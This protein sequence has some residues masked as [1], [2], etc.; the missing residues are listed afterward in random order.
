[1]KQLM[2]KTRKAIYLLFILVGFSTVPTKAQHASYQIF[3]DAL[4]PYGQWIMDPQ[5]G[6]V[7]IPDAGPDFRPYY[8]NGRWVMTEYGN[9]WVSGY[10]WGWAPFHYGRWT[11]NRRFGWVWIP[12]NVWGPAWVSWRSGG[13]YYGW[14]PL[15]PGINVHIAFGNNYYVPDAWWTF[16]PCRYIYHKNFHHHWKGHKHNTTFIHNTTII[17]NTYNN[18]YV[19]GPR[20]A[21]VEKHVGKRVP[22]YELKNETQPGKSLVRNRNLNVYRP[23]IEAPDKSETRPAPKQFVRAEKPVVVKPEARVSAQPRMRKENNQKLLPKNEQTIPRVMGA[24]PVEREKVKPAQQSVTPKH[25]PTAQ[26]IQPNRIKPTTRGT[27]RTQPNRIE[28]KAS[29]AK[30]IDAQRQ[31]SARQWQRPVP[32]QPQRVEKAQPNPTAPTR[33]KNNS[34]A[35]ALRTR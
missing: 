18:T 8:T 35:P 30:T 9:T 21:E 29:P 25:R 20:R 7:W 3:Y 16:V 23:Q 5:Y 24:V 12:D 26:E 1:M 34:N 27:E 17:N 28:Q 2:S 22:V 4:A 32:G 6:Y 11:F 14:A 19:Y 13:G 33:E 31:P 15:G 10:E